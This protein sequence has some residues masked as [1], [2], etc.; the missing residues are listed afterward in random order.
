[1][2]KI[3]EE[4]MRTLDPE[5]PRDFIDMYLLQM[6]SDGSRYNKGNLNTVLID[7]F[8]AGTETSSTTLKWA[9]LFLTLNQAVQDKCREEILQVLGPS[10]QPSLANLKDLPYTQ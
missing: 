3:V 10:G 9:L 4:H 8:S 6:R 7:F 5:Q 2:L 1:M